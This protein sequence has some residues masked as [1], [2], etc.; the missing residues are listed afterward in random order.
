MKTSVKKYA[1]FGLRTSFGVIVAAALA[2][3][4]V[5]GWAKPT[6]T[7]G[8]SAQAASKVGNGHYKLQ[9]LW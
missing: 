7:V 6:T 8:G 1:A 4:A 2:A 5:S 3:A 9:P